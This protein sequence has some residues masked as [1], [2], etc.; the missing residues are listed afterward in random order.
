MK[1]DWN[2]VNSVILFN[3]SKIVI[4]DKLNTNNQL[5]F[6]EIKTEILFGIIW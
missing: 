2:W 4:S 6:E 3:L 1:K 5:L